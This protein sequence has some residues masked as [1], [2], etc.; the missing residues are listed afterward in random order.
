MVVPDPGQGERA[1]IARRVIE[2]REMCST[3]AE[4]F[5]NIVRSIEEAGP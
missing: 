5:H 1:T 4:D 2:A 3:R